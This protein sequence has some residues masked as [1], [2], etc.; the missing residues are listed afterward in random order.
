MGIKH[1]LYLNSRS[2]RFATI[3]AALSIPGVGMKAVGSEGDEP[4]A[5]QPFA[6]IEDLVNKVNVQDLVELKD[7]RLLLVMGPEALGAYSEDDGKTWGKPFELKDEAGTPLKPGLGGIVVM[8]SG[9]LGFYQSVGSFTYSWWRSEDNGKTWSQ[10]FPINPVQGKPVSFY[11]IPRPFTEAVQNEVQ[12]RDQDQAVVLSSGRIVIPCYMAL[13][14]P[15]SPDYPKYP[16]GMDCEETLL[17]SLILF[18]DDEGKTWQRSHSMVFIILPGR[19]GSDEEYYSTERGKGGFWEFEEPTLVELKDGRLMMFGRSVLGRT[20]ASYSEDQGLNW[21][22]PV[23][24]PIASPNAPSTLTR[25]SNGSLLLIWSQTSPEEN[26]QGYSRHRL[27]TAISQ[28]EGKTWTDHKNLESL[29]DVVFIEPPALETL[30]GVYGPH[31]KYPTDTTRY[32][33][34]GTGALRIGYPHA[35]VLQDTVIVDYNYGY[36]GDAIG[37]ITIKQRVLPLS[38]FTTH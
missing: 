4:L 5:E 30:H 38:W 10:G 25:L 14:G 12:I 31:Y 19:Y 28:D 21:D 29:D 3:V 24:M 32:H 35:R 8:K 9:A 1:C 22:A 33:G 11:G 18:S 7:G 16:L 15:R 2:I 17:Y 23:P 34:I 13:S 37:K 6:G 36:P 27:S 20:F 26:I